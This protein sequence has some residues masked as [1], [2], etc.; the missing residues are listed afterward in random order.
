[1]T[2]EKRDGRIVQLDESKIKRAI[3]YAASAAK[4][5]IA[6]DLYD[7]L[8]KFVIQKVSRLDEPI[9]IDSIHLAVEDS[10]MKYNLFDVMRTYRDYRLERD[11]KRFLQ[12]KVV[13]EME[14]KY[15]CSHNEHQNANIDENS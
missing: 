13:K 5:E 15:N 8:V 6:D 12:L 2:V 7:K 1:M 3:K 10:L 4:V 11:K 9:K 14:A